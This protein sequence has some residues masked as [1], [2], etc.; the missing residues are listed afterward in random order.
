ML[1][2]SSSMSENC[3]TPPT[4]TTML[5]V[6]HVRRHDDLLIGS[7]QMTQAE[8]DWVTSPRREDHV[9]HIQPIGDTMLGLLD[10]VTSEYAASRET[11]LSIGETRCRSGSEAEVAR[12]LIVTKILV[13]TAVG[14]SGSI[15]N[16]VARLP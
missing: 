14:L 4:A 13:R 3:G 11:S 6:L 12:T 9:G 2:V 5:T 8:V 16:Q 7:Y 15:I 1:Q 10:G